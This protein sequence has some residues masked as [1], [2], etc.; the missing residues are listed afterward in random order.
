VGWPQEAAREEADGSGRE[1]R[2]R[3]EA[4]AAREIQ[5]ER[6]LQALAD[7][8]AKRSALQVCVCVCG[9]IEPTRGDG[10]GG[11]AV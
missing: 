9:T 7:R 11:M 4:F 6:E 1:L 2:S 3:G 10:M 8:L 5:M